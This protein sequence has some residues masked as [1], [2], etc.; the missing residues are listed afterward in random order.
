MTDLTAADFV[1]FFEAAWGLAPFS[2]QKMLA[3]RILDEGG[4]PGAIALPT[5]AGKTACLDI[6]VFALAA[7]AGLLA[8]GRP[9]TEPRRIFYVVDRRIIVDEA[10]DRARTLAEKLRNA[11]NGILKTVADRLR[12]LAAGDDPLACFQLR[13]GMYRDDAWAR[14]P[15]QPTIITST[16][17]QMGSRLLF[18]A[19]G[20]SSRAW[21]IQAGLA[22]ND[23]LILLDEAH[24]AQPFLE[25]LQA[26]GRYRAQASE[27]LGASFQIT[28]MSATPPAGLIDVFR[29]ESREPA[30]P[31]HPLGDRQLA[32]KP[33]R[34]VPVEKAK[35]AKAAEEL[36][37]ALVAQAEILS[38]GRPLATV[39]F[40][41][42]VATARRTHAL[43]RGQYGDRA[44]LLTGRMRPIDRD[45]TVAVWLK[46][47]SA[48]V[49]RERR[50]DFPLF[51]VAT[52]TLEVGA[53]LDFDV[54]VTEAASLD[55]LRQRF[56]RLNRMGRP[57]PA[58]AAV[59]IRAD[60]TADSDD[61]P[62]Y[63]PALAATWQWLKDQAGEA[64]Y[65]DMGIAALDK[66]LPP[67][68]SMVR[69]N[70]PAAH[71]PVMFPSH[72][73]SWAQTA[74]DPMPSPDVAFFLHGPRRAAADVQVCWRAD[75]DLDAD[76]E[77]WLDALAL[78]PPT[79]AECLPVPIGSM[80]RWLTGGDADAASES[81]VEGAAL[82]EEARTPDT[83]EPRRV[84]LWRNREEA[85]STFGPDT[86]RP[87]DVVV[88][89]AALGGFDVLGDVPETAGQVRADWAERAH[90]Q[91]RAQ[92]MLRLHPVVIAGWR[93]GEAGEHLMELA[94]RGPALIE[95]DSEGL[96]EELRTALTTLANEPV[97]PWLAEIAR[98]LARDR[99]LKKALT[100][101][102]VAGLVVRGN[103]PLPVLPEDNADH[104]GDEDDASAS[105]T[106]RVH[107]NTHLA[108]VAEYARRF[109]QG[110]GLPVPVVEDLALAGEAHDLGKADPRFQALLY[111]GNPWA[112]GP[113][114]AKSG[115]LPAG[116]TSF[117]N[118]RKRVGYPKG[119]RHELLSLRLLQSAP[120][121]LPRE[122]AR[123]ELVLHL[124]A[125][126]HGR[127]RPF[128]PV[129]ED[130]DPRTVAIEFRGHT[131]TAIGGTRLERLDS[132]VARR[133]WYLI[134]LYGW[135]GL[136]W[137][138]AILRLADHRSSEAEQS[139][140]TRQEED[141]V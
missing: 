18:R 9:L 55:A 123:R 11:G 121:L 118:A 111:G 68:E 129:V 62:V 134:R 73:D 95:E 69:L 56:G 29:D 47:L 46:R 99:R 53:N 115:D 63:G 48:D 103:R 101:H 13:G 34:L 61:D 36:A 6:A 131:L 7:R 17:D 64:A 32:A 27:P 124:V 24:C 37:N 83:T 8:P 50:L 20:R 113:L 41:N 15:I 72:I 4:W 108:G 117:E 97:Q 16:V 54:L 19:Y 130:S 100:L 127:C 125:S 59:L 23:S 35:G 31:G 140:E 14:S 74:P 25:T 128:A 76:G 33:T 98:H 106:S 141:N 109:A 116:R 12:K 114:L 84:V 71:A 104:F 88:I 89:P 132:G 39:I 21:P 43:L 87:G 120:E 138:E 91:S 94:K 42:R 82:D 65:V 126:H 90:R 139:A 60:Q 92:A 107:L 49:S 133:F 102:P 75:L 86:L 93:A 105:G 26:V 3:I 136:A 77:R 40:V 135:W 81:D 1:A 2:W 44:V 112:R 66:R 119:G 96:V 30:T 78:C 28:V 57:G 137:F 45:D 22:A 10:F 38:E 52:Q 51:V 70:A 80:R 85:E 58:P 110:C 67:P 5:A 122:E 79:I